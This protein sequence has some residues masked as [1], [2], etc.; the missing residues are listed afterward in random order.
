MSKLSLPKNKDNSQQC[1]HFPDIYQK[2][3]QIF[4]INSL[5]ENLIDWS[6]CVVY[7]FQPL[8]LDS[9]VEGDISGLPLWVKS[10][11]I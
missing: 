11:E 10:Q 9:I 6:Y 2:W 4:E 5:L 7:L 8:R 1:P 3:M